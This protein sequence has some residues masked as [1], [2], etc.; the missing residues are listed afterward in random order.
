M[1]EIIFLTGFIVILLLAAK[2]IRYEV[3]GKE[4]NLNS[5]CTLI[6]LMIEAFCTE[7]VWNLV[8]FNL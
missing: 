8:V 7:L 2:V 3:G 1:K 4:I 6:T 5:C